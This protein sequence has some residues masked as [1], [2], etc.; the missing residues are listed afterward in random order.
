MSNAYGYARVSTAMQKESG[1]GIDAQE[2]TIN[3]MWAAYLQPAGYGAV[4][5]F[6]DE[7]VSRSKA[8]SERPG[9]RQVCLVAGRGDAIVIPKFD[10][11][12]G[13]SADAHAQM[14]AWDLTGIRVICPDFAGSSYDS[15]SPMSK[16]QL[17][18]LAMCAEWEHDRICER[19]NDRIA[20][21]RA[22]GRPSHGVAPYG[23][24]IVKVFGRRHYQPNPAERALMAKLV[25]FKEKGYTLRAIAAHLNKSR[26]P[27]RRILRHGRWV[28]GARWCKDKVQL[29]IE[30]EYYYRA[31]ARKV[32][33]GHF[34]TPHGVILPI[35]GQ[36]DVDTGDGRDYTPTPPTETITADS[37][38]TP[39]QTAD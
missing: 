36:E 28:P 22:L 2:A 30:A 5:I 11:A 1:L 4:T 6:R 34:V 31:Q 18:V 9:G 39:G 35:M 33:A 14:A 21:C 20:T 8:F 12:F 16:V 37:G 27:T 3:R 13:R 15:K 38:T 7:A 32:P 25:E 26:V 29:M 24:R 23:L 10:R 19:N 17:A